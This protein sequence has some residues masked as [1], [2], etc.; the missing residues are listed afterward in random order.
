MALAEAEES[1]IP[2]RCTVHPCPP[3][4]HPT[5]G[6][7]FRM[8]AATVGLGVALTFGTGVALAA[9][10]D[11]S[12][13]SGGTGT[14]TGAEASAPP[15]SGSS[16][17]EAEGG[18]DPSGAG[19]APTA[20]LVSETPP[21]ATISAQQTTSTSDTPVDDAV[22]EDLAEDLEENAEED[23]EVTAPQDETAALPET[24]AAV[25][26]AAEAGEQSSPAAEEPTGAG[27]SDP[28]QSRSATDSSSPA[29]ESLAAEDI[30]VAPLSAPDESAPAAA[31]G[32]VDAVAAASQSTPAAGPDEIEIVIEVVTGRDVRPNPVRTV[33]LGLL[34][35]FGFDPNAT[36]PPANPLVPVLDVIWGIYRRIENSVAD[37]LEFVGFPAR[38]TVITQVT[39][40]VVPEEYTALDLLASAREFNG[41]YSAELDEYF[42]IDVQ[43]GI[44]TYT[45]A[46]YPS[47]SLHYP[48]DPPGQLIT[49]TQP[50]SW[51]PSG[52]SGHANMT[53]VYDY[54]VATLS[55]ES[56]D[57]AGAPVAVIVVSD[58]LNNAYWYRSQQVFVFGHDFEAALDI[59]GHEYTHAV[60]DEVVRG[61]H[62]EI[63]G[64]DAQSRAL[65]EAYSDILGG[66]I[67]G[68]SGPGRW[69]FGEDRG[70]GQGAG[71]CALRNMAV[72][73]QYGGYSSYDQFDAS[74]KEHRNSTIFSHAAY[75]M[76]TASA[77]AEI[78]DDEWAQV[79]YGS[80]YRLTPGA[81]FAEAAA[82]VIAE[83]EA[84]GFEDDEVATIRQA[85]TDVDI[86]VPSEANAVAA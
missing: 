85:F 78:T 73:S 6:R 33:V 28:S 58:I 45:A 66:L 77:T 47:G 80:L 43:R 86:P 71:Q 52:V 84:F 82:A 83:A 75:K 18:L 14:T 49:A 44:R 12:D 74:A 38:S 55:R 30:D 39:T 31:V 68:K 60:I 59:V 42:L 40:L 9:P 23:A 37:A 54:Y 69:L 62:G 2:R 57:G 29:T 46:T 48:I 19:V 4:T 7:W 16:G 56:Y 8:G 81:T 79:F 76:M 64:Q 5:S 53:V 67:E 51:D 13:T 34:G 25:A 63:L 27:G 32:A 26:E 1:G 17:T 72:P 41:V 70:C 61:Q 24:D 36:I 20:T 50:T 21:T 15:E 10:G 11:A 22:E 35:L 3:S 65:E